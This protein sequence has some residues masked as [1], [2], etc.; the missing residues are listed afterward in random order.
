ME[1]SW[2]LLIKVSS[3]GFELQVV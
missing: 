2:L 1:I 3:L